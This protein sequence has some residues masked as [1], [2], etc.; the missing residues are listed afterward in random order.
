MEWGCCLTFWGIQESAPPP[1]S[2]GPLNQRLEDQEEGWIRPQE[3]NSL[4]WQGW[5]DPFSSRSGLSSSTLLSP[6]PG[7]K[8]RALR[9]QSLSPSSRAL[10]FVGAQEA[11][12]HYSGALCFLRA[13]L[14]GR[15]CGN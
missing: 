13:S 10:C 12:R 7:R 2:K 14:R 4:A 11:P 5:L 15:R 6:G 3:E 9:A 8:L 1:E